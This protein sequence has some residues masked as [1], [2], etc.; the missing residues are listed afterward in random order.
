MRGILLL[1]LALL[2]A[3]PTWARAFESTGEVRLAAGGRGASAAFDAT[4]VVGPAVNLT[5]TAGGTWSG[6]LHGQSVALEVTD[7]RISAPNV[8]LFVETAGGVTSV[9]GNLFGRRYSLEYGPKKLAGRTGACAVD[10]KRTRQGNL[11]GTT[12]CTGPRR[13]PTVTRT[14]VKLLGQARDPAPPF[15]Q[16]VLALLAVLP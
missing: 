9:R 3:A 10:L 12:G 1:P 15:P 6:D 11:A 7:R 5:Q 16:F 13:T 14:F 8:E 4:R 2:S